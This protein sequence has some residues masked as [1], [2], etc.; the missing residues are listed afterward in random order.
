MGL[1]DVLFL[2][3]VFCLAAYETTGGEGKGSVLVV[4]S[5]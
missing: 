4:L 3:F 5:A 2:F 1:A